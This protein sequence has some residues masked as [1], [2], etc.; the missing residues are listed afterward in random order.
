MRA[1]IHLGLNKCASTYVQT[2]LDAA[3]SDLQRHGVWYPDQPGPCCHY[4]LSRNYGFG[5][6]DPTVDPC[7]LAELADSAARRGCDRLILSSEYLSLKAPRAADRLLADLQ[8]NGI[9]AEFVLFSREIY[10]WVRA[11]FNQFVKTVDGSEQPADL[12]AF[13][14]RVL[15]NGAIDI[16]GRIGIWRARLPEAAL[17]HYRLEADAEPG[18]VLAPFEC[19]AGCRL[20]EPAAGANTS[21]DA[22]RI[23]RIGQLRRL[24]PCPE[25][26]AEI[27]TI[28]AGGPVAALAPEGYLDIDMDR[29]DRIMVEVSRPY[30]QIPRSPLPERLGATEPALAS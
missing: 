12:N 10:A 25:R 14:D 19:F 18:A 2:A 11:L 1:L 29:L 8:A 3:R 27:A 4:G 26:N 6:E 15:A 24:T 21:L 7:T 20:P 30:Y 13:I 16:A 22:D 23:Y 28:L 17:H 9:R 5:P